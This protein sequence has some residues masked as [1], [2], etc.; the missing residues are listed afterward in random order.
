MVLRSFNEIPWAAPILGALMFLCVYDAYTYTDELLTL[1]K[2]PVEIDIKDA[3]G[4]EKSDAVWVILSGVTWNCPAKLVEEH[5]GK[6]EETIPLVSA[7]GDLLV[8]YDPPDSSKNAPRCEEL[9]STSASGILKRINA[10]RYH[11]LMTR[12]FPIMK[13]FP[14]H[15]IAS[16]CG[17]CGPEN[18]KWGAL[19]MGG[20]AALFGAGLVI[21][22][23][24]L[25]C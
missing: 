13:Q 3:F 20:M 24:K 18:S 12:D 4:P 22:L 8:I 5:R 21:C 17:Y 19:F 16:L 10:R 14:Q 9:R 6:R 1:P 11:Y 23:F 7:A 2:H 15:N 25:R